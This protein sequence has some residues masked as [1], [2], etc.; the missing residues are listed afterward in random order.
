MLCLFNGNEAQAVW[1][2]NIFNQICP[3]Q[4]KFTFEFSECSTIFLN[5]KLIL[6]RDT[7]RID[8]DY[9]VKPTNKQLFLHFRSCHPKHVFKAIVYNQALLPT[10]VCS[11]L[12][13]RDQYLQNLREKF[14]Q[15]EYPAELIDQEF[16][17]AKTMNRKDLIMK[18]KNQKKPEKKKAE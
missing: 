13:W 8:I 7:D 14:T 16:E 4:V 17:R 18:K 15:Q 6:N 5:L 9:Y 2:I 11:K 3:G 10:M 12:E 1:L